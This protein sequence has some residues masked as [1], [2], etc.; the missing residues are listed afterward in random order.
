[1]VLITFIWIA[2]AGFLVLFISMIFGGDVDSDIDADFDADVDA[3]LDADGGGFSHW[4]SVKVL[5]AFTTA[6]GAGGA[7]ARAYGA[8]DLWTYVVAIVSGLL[9]GFAAQSIIHFFYRQQSTSS[10]RTDNLEG[11]TG[12]VTLGILPGGVGEV[13]LMVGSNTFCKPARSEDGAEIKQGERVE[14]VFSQSPL[15]VR[16][17]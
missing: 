8:S 15:I 13:K 11:K 17:V 3:D 6:F 7:S 12:M 14:V 9:V 5:A 16:K 10:Y 1:M 4:F 2:L